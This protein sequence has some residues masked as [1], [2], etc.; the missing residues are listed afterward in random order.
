VFKKTTMKEKIWYGGK[1]SLRLFARAGVGLL[2]IWLNLPFLCQG[3]TQV[4]LVYKHTPTDHPK[5]Q[6]SGYRAME[7]IEQS[8]KTALPNAAITR[9]NPNEITIE[10]FLASLEKTSEAAGPMGTIIIYTHSHGFKNNPDHGLVGGLSLGDNRKEAILPWEDYAKTLANLKNKNI[11]VLTM[12]CFSGNLVES[13]NSQ[14]ITPLWK[15][16]TFL[17]ITSQDSLRPSKPI[18]INSTIINPFTYSIISLLNRT[19]LKN[20]EIEELATKIIEKTTSTQSDNPRFRNTANPQLTGSY[21]N[22]ELLFK[23]L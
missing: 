5:L 12:A 16:K 13:L 18:S 14:E 8:F 15:N 3:Q 4:L 23:E 21:K 20:L 9:L 1:N 2:I 7:L 22:G 11:I 19:D 17:V 10:G 6:E